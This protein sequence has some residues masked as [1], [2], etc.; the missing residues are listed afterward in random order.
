MR[1]SCSSPA[2]PS[3]AQDAEKGE[4]IFVNALRPE[5]TLIHLPITSGRWLL[6]DDGHAVVLNHDRANKLGVK[7]GDKVWISLEG[8]TRSEWTVVGTVFDLSNLQRS[9]YVPLAVY[10]RE[11]GLIGR[12]P[13]SGC[14]PRPTTGQ[15]NCRSRSS[16]GI[17][18]SAKG[19]RVGNTQTAEQIRPQNES[20]FGIITRM[21]YGHVGLDRRRRR[22]RVG[23]HALDQCAGAPPRDRRDARH[24]RIVAHDR[25][26]VH[27]RRL[28]AGPD[29][30]ADCH[31]AQHSGGAGVCHRHRSGDSIRASSISSRGMAR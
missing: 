1:C 14:R 4:D 27:R 24:R 2:P 6:P 10:Q 3:S 16:Y 15:P 28:D 11:V 23:G 18:L 17:A 7:V 20:V 22:D 8:D 13:R 5:S 12:A 19:V 26:A 29:R 9:V 31:S 21:L 25:G 30:L